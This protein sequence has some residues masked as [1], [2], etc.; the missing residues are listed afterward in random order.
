MAQRGGNQLRIIAG[1]WR[2]RRLRFA[3]V[4]G[5]RPTG[6]RNRETLFNWLQP[7]IRGSC[8]LD[9]FAG[10]GALGFEA[11]SRGARRVVLVERAA[12]AVR[13]L[14]ENVHLLGAEARIEVFQGDA[15]QF[16]R[17]RPA[18]PFD[19]VFLDPPFDSGLLADTCS[20]LESREWL[21]GEALVYMEAP[22]SLGLPSLPS[23]WEIHR[24]REAGQVLYALIRRHGK[25]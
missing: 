1:E 20:L 19:I 25:H 22:R 11:A 13:C 5:L 6:D 8:C 2:G 15:V 23:N 16:L 21:A 10:S 4:P 7:R 24:Q 14:R 9:L 3:N 18:K 12:A 17:N